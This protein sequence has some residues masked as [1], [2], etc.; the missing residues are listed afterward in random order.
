MND[1][2]R[3]PQ[4]PATTQ[5]AEGM[6][7]RRW[8][9]AE[10]EQMV[11]AGIIGE[12]ERI[13]LLGGEVVPM[14]PK[15]ATHETVK[16]RLDRF[17]QR[18]APD[19]IAVIPETTLRLSPDTYVEPDFCVFASAVGIRGLS[20]ST[21]LLAVEIADSSLGY[22]LGRKIGVCAA[23]GVAEVWVINASTLETRVHRKLGVEGYSEV[24]AVA[25]DDALTPSR[26]RDLSVSL[27]A[28]GLSPVSGALDT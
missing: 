23:Y 11:A 4:L 19:S 9:V 15:G 21:V 5:A 10:I 7:R 8:S 24:F 13:E 26:A 18:T 14:S 2:A 20:G 1:H 28:L 3:S 27:K 25:A 22:D 17:F 12:H 6:G 16:W